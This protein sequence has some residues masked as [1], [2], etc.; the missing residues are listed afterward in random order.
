MKYLF[1]LAM[2][3]VYISCQKRVDSLEYALRQAGDNR[4]ELEKV[5]QHYQGI[6]DKQKL[7][8]ACFLIANMPG[9]VSIID[10]MAEEIFYLV[11]KDWNKFEK[12][13]DLDAYLKPVID[14]IKRHS[15][16]ETKIVKDIE[17]IKSGFLI[18]NIDCSFEMWKKPWATQYNF[19][20]FCEYIL[21]YRVRT[22]PLSPWK[23]E[24][25]ERYAWVEDS[26]KN[27]KNSEE[28][29]L[30]LN[31][32]IGID[33]KDLDKS[34]D[35]IHYAPVLQMLDTKAGICEHRYVIVT[36]LLRAMGIASAIDITPQINQWFRGHSWTVFFDSTGR[37]RPFDGGDPRHVPFQE[38]PPSGTFPS[39]TVMPMREALCSNVFR[40]KYSINENSLPYTTARLKE[41]K[42][43]RFFSEICMENVTKEYDMSQMT[44]SYTL[45]KDKID[46]SKPVFLS[47]VS[48]HKELVPVD[49]AFA[50]KGGRVSFH[51]I[52]CASVYFLSQYN[53][54]GLQAISQPILF[55]D[56]ICGNYIILQPD[57][58]KRNSVLLTRKCKISPQM[59]VFAES[60]TGA[61]FQGSHHPKFKDAETFYTITQ[62]P[63][64][65]E[66]QTVEPSCNY[67]FVRYL[68]PDK[69]IHIA[70]IQFCTKDND[71]QERLLTGSPLYYQSIKTED[72][73]IDHAFDQDIRTNTDAPEGSWIGL[74]LGQETEIT[75]IKYL[76]R[77]NFNVIEIG[78]L[79][80][81]FY[82]DNEW[83]SLG[84]KTA[85]SQFLRYD[86]VPSNA[87]L[88][89]ENHTQGKE[90]RIFTYEN[91]RQVWW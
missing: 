27:K 7:E 22:E 15:N 23:K 53:K 24:L 44:F 80:E 38:N 42:I 56:S 4:V 64:Y 61:M 78:N 16:D 69:E 41:V 60:M 47:Y 8:A 81:L 62:A 3:F 37:A 29:A 19:K 76:P 72:I 65:L 10:P 54:S 26:V 34:M 33:Y 52:A 46:A 58:T 59:K 20:Q 51:N 21:P 83:K 77:N 48:Y 36:A 57:V 13:R 91:G 45:N 67:R 79:Y 63:E 84:Q 32:L 66:E 50:D 14:S 71:G 55:P 18:E 5:I 88:L 82:F 31:D 90:E 74:D 73:K 17:T 85:D 30:Y 12:K 43:P 89:L 6:G 11:H 9:K 49:W 86:D 1:L 40:Y 75:K 39:T 28:I 87:L 25:L 68:S 35:G 2:V 70:E